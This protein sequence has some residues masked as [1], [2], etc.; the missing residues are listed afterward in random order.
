MTP[1]F[2]SQIRLKPG[3]KRLF[4]SGAAHVTFIAELAVVARLDALAAA[5]GV[6]KAELLR[7]AVDAYLAAQGRA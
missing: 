1:E 7:A 2:K 5:R 3:R 4:R 6:P